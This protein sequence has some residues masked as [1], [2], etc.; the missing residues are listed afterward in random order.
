MGQ[1]KHRLYN[2]LTVFGG[3]LQLDSALNKGQE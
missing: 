2:V 1:Q 3:I